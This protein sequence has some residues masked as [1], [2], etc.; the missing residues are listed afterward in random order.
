[1]VQDEKSEAMTAEVV[2]LDLQARLRLRLRRFGV[3]LIRGDDGWTCWEPR[4]KA[5]EVFRTLAGRW[6]GKTMPQTVEALVESFEAAPDGVRRWAVDM[7][8]IAQGK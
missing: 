4:I 3:E 7:Y 6:D 5:G 1:M 8:N 2:P